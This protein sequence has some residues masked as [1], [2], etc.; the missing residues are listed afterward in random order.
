MAIEKKEQ[1]EQLYNGVDSA[2]QDMA[3]MIHDSVEKLKEAALDLNA[4]SRLKAFQSI[5]IR[6]N[7]LLVNIEEMDNIKIDIS[8]NLDNIIRNIETEPFRAILSKYSEKLE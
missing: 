4:H 8:S 6:C 1:V 3:D 5:D 2:L 7:Q